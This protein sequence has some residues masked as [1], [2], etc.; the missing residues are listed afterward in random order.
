MSA[1]VATI[2]AVADS[3]TQPHDY[4]SNDLKHDV[5]WVENNKLVMSV[6]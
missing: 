4:L 5:N 2:A 3:Q 1:D 6:I